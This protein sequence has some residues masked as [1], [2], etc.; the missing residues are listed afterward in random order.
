MIKIFEK[1]KK[2]IKISNV[3][4][5][6]EKSLKTSIKCAKK[7]QIKIVNNFAKK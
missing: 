1:R 4:K 5:I 2:F 3:V 7:H 6:M